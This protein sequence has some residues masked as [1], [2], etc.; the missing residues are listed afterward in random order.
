[1]SR[2]FTLVEVLVALVVLAVGLLGAAAML[3]ETLQGSRIALERSRA[4]VLAADMAERLRANRAAGNAYDTV[5]GTP[6]PQLEPACEQ[7]GAGC[8]AATMASHDLR[9]WQDAVAEALPQG[10]GTVDVAPLSPTANRCTIRLTW[11]QTG[12]AVPAT[13]TLVAD[14]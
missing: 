7:A 4:V 11:A 14:P 9:R 3:L 8:H 1:M 13:F 12:S 2:G 5:D 6:D 10:M